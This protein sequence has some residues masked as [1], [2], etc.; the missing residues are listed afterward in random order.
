MDPVV[1]ALATAGAVAVWCGLGAMLLGS[2]P[3][4]RRAMTVTAVRGP[5]RLVL[6]SSGKAAGAARLSRA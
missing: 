1:A 3:R 4:L 5:Q 2:A 6:V